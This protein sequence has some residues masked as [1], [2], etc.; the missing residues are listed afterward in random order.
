[1]HLTDLSPADGD[2]RSVTGRGPQVAQHAKGSPGAM[3]DR[4][5]YDHHSPRR[6][7]WPVETRDGAVAQLGERRVRNAKVRGSIPLGSTIL[8]KQI[9]QLRA[10]AK[11][12]CTPG[13]A[14]SASYQRFTLG[15]SARSTW[16]R[17]WRQAQPRIA[18][19]AIEIS[20]PANSTSPSRRSRTA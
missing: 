7:T 5:R 6:S 10:T 20:P 4:V 11:P 16:W 2:D 15:K 8:L 9:Y 17:S 14:I 18:K 1:M 12:R 19:S 13:R 3:L